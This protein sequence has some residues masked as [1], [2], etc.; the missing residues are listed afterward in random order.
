MT[1]ESRPKRT[2]KELILDAAFSFCNEPRY[3]SFSLSELAAKVGITKTAIYRHFKDKDA[4]FTGMYNR[5]C[6]ELASCLRNVQSVADSGVIPTEP[7]ADVI[8]FFIENP[9]YVNYMFG[10][11]ASVKDFEW[12]LSKDLEERGIVNKTAGFQYEPDGS[13]KISIKN[14]DEYIRNIYWGVT[15]FIFI[16]SRKKASDCGKK[17]DSAIDF[18]HKLVRFLFV[19]LSSAVKKENPLYPQAITASRREELVKL[20]SLR[21][22][23]LPPENRFFTAFASAI[24][25]YKLNG[26]TVEKIAAELNMAKSSLYEYFDNKNSMLKALLIK[27]MELLHTVVTENIAEARSFSEYFY[28]LMR[29]ECE[30]F[31]MRPSSI[32]ILGW[33]LMNSSDE[34]FVN[35]IDA[36]DHWQLRMETAVSALDLGM[37]I[38]A[39]KFIGWVSALPVSLVMQCHGHALGKTEMNQALDLVFDLLE[40]GIGPKTV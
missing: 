14:F 39:R 16:K 17:V 6:D 13:G 1:N 9:H 15:I 4:V 11:L 2:T 7:I 10:S 40:N 30:F 22:D 12:Q 26:V 37:D 33:L 23:M 28:V 25:K 20:C 36:Q 27:E 32:P 29:T 3:N 8:A 24:R 31:T 34:E 5:F 21:D 19:G 18:S 35:E 38:P